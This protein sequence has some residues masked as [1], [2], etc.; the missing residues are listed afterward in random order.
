MPR[1][2]W[3]PAHDLSSD[4]RRSAAP[5]HLTLRLCR[6]SSSSMSVEG[7]HDRSCVPCPSSSFSRSLHHGLDLSR[8]SPVSAAARRLLVRFG[9]GCSGSSPSTSPSRISPICCAAALHGL[10]LLLLLRPPR[11]P[12]FYSLVPL[13]VSAHSPLSSYPSAGS[14]GSAA[15]HNISLLRCGSPTSYVG[16]ADSRFAHSPPAPYLYPRF[17]ISARS[18]LSLHLALLPTSSRS[19]TGS[20][21]SAAHPGSLLP[22]CG[23]PTL[24]VGTADSCSAPSEPLPKLSQSLP[25]AILAAL[26][27]DFCLDVADSCLRLRRLPS[28]KNS[29]SSW[30]RYNTS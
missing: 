21:G 27:A 11:F 29:S 8:Q 14:R 13:H 6:S 15:H 9:W 30:L 22:R 3:G 20:R 24:Y 7:L 18:P 10:L 5:F 16:T 17:L 1:G 12:P 26:H 19:P 25:S 4:A 2:L 23:G 28:L